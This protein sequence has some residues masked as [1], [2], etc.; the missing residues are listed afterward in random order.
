MKRLLLTIAFTVA[1]MTASAQ[2]TREGTPFCTSRDMLETAQAAI[3]AGNRP[4]IQYLVSSGACGQ[5]R[6]GLNMVIVGGDGQFLQV[7]VF[8]PDGSRHVDLWVFPTA[9]GASS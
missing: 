6:A 4:L 7:R 1:A 8:T 5:L 9:F 3:A 2:T